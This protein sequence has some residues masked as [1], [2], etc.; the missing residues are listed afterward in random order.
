MLIAMHCHPVRRCELDVPDWERA[1]V[2]S[3]FLFPWENRPAPATEFRAVHDGVHLHF[4]FDCVDADLVLAE[5]DS[6][7]RVLGSDRVE[8]FFAAD[9]GL[10]PY[11][12]FEMEPRGAVLAYRGRF[13][14][15]FDWDWSAPDLRLQTWLGK[16]GYRVEGRLPLADL[17]ALGV[18]RPGSGKLLTGVHRGEFG[19]RPDGSVQP[20]WVTWVDPQTER[21]DFHVPSA[22]GI[23]ELE[24]LV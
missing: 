14:R 9:M 1:A 23:L 17:R 2:L 8:L 3:D 16:G 24:A 22:F 4:R 7:A 20:G 13:H 5:G 6:H 19:H 12:C 21:P 18:L 11:Y 15:Q 10:D